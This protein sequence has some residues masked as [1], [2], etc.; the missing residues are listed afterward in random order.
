MSGFEI[1]IYVGLL[2][3]CIGYIWRISFDHSDSLSALERKRIQ[4][5]AYYSE[6]LK[7]IT[8]VTR[9]KPRTE[10]ESKTDDANFLEVEIVPHGDHISLKFELISPLGNQQTTFFKLDPFALN[11]SY[12]F[13]LGLIAFYQRYSDAGKFGFLTIDLRGLLPKVA[14]PLDV[15]SVIHREFHFK[16]GS[17]APKHDDTSQAVPA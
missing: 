7:H 13:F 4:C 14:N 16:N 3:L 5:T 12:F 6:C 15:G 2:F 9:D 10:D 17:G 8:N 1:S 11:Q